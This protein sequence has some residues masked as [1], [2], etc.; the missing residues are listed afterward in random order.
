MQRVTCVTCVTRV[1]WDSEGADEPLGQSPHDKPSNAQR[2]ETTNKGCGRSPRL[3][4]TF[5]RLELLSYAVGLSSSG[6]DFLF[7]YTISLIVERHL[8]R[9]PFS[10]SSPKPQSLT[11]NALVGDFISEE[12]L[13]S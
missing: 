2:Q 5:N 6:L 11:S 9:F 13:T 8:M 1:V 12:T 3:K 4:K 10:A 7:N